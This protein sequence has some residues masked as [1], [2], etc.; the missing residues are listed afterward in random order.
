MKQKCSTCH[1]LKNL[2]DFDFLKNGK[3]AKTCIS[4]VNTSKEYRENNKE[5]ISKKN[6]DRYNQNREKRILKQK[7]YYEQNRDACIE[8]NKISYEKNKEQYKKYKKEYYSENKEE[9][10]S[11]Q[12]QDRKNNPEKYLLK[13][14][15]KR[16]KEKNLPFNIK[17]EDIIIP[18]VC[19]IFGFPLECGT[20]SERDNSPSLDRVIPELGY[21][22]GNV[23]VISFKANTLKRDGHIEDFEK[24]ISY[25]KMS[26]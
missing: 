25:I 26:I 5:K 2:D 8:R 4:C 22:K 21:V 16:A 10:L 13:A 7:Q 9:I 23:N 12:K 14:A 11:E 17:I 18:K 3:K 19:P 6:K 20:I 15:R 1:V 24:I